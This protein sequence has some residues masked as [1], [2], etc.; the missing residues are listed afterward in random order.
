MKK[1]RTNSGSARRKKDQ[2][3]RATPRI[4][5]GRLRSPEI[6]AEPSS[7]ALDALARGLISIGEKFFR[8]GPMLRIP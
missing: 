8:S 6:D 1:P 4:D 5:R 3:G 7:S 2:D